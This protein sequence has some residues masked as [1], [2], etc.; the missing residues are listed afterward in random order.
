MVLK[1]EE[2][3]A[4]DELAAYPTGEGIDPSLVG[5]SFFNKAKGTNLR[6]VLEIVHQMPE[7]Q[8][9][10]KEWSTLNRLLKNRTLQQLQ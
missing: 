8:W 4:E 3:L 9:R 10:E 6:N 1:N 5:F 7:I 2:Q